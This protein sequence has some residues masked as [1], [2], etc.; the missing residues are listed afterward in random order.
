MSAWRSTGLL[1][2]LTGVLPAV[3]DAQA[4]TL[5][6]VAQQVRAHAGAPGA[7]VAFRSGHRE[8]IAASG[9]ADVDTR[10]SMTGDVPFYLGSVTKTYTATVVMRLVEE[11]R[12]ALA[13]T[14]GRFFPGFPGGSM[15][16][17]AHLLNHTSGLKDFYSYL[18][19]RPD[20]KEMIEF[21]T[22]HWSEAELLALSARF[23]RWFEPGTDW[24]YSSTNYFLLGAIIE[25]VT[26][27]PLD[28][29]YD[30]YLFKPLGLPETWLPA[31]TRGRGQL[32]T[33]YM[34]WVPSWKHS[35]MFGSLGPTTAL[36]QS[37]NEGAAG[38]LAASASDALRFLE[39]LVSGRLVA[40]ATY[41]RMTE[42]VP[43]PPLGGTESGTTRTDGY[44]LGLISMDRAGFRLIGHG[45]L[46]NGHTAGLWY[47]PACDV[48][49]A[50]YVNR[51]FID[52]RAALDLI[53]G[54]VAASP[55]VRG[56]TR[57]PQ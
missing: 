36:D 26:G 4:G 41:A 2:A 44:G 24:S 54:Y 48:T 47:L 52:V 16:T 9:L 18:Y 33:G 5:S 38:G 45:G 56:C 28:Q 23:G 10:R 29:A 7:I 37:P 3:T 55:E 6:A 13:D 8:H 46:F 11:G 49:I 32:S 35:E 50:L 20:R 12:L 51:G 40:S 31:R 39:G 19:Y 14:I 57:G 30:R 17:V 53:V 25:R 27:F 15:T 34:G 43:T 42:F 22:R 21:V 1:C